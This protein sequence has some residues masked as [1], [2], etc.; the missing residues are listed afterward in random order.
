MSDSKQ[1]SPCDCP[2]AWPTCCPLGWIIRTCSWLYNKLRS[3]FMP[4]DFNEDASYLKAVEWLQKDFRPTAA[5]EGYGQALQYAWRKLDSAASASET[6]D[7]KAMHLMTTFT[8]IS[9]VLGVAINA[10]HVANPYL[11]MP[12]L[13]A[14]ASAS[15]L[16]AIACN[17]AADA[18]IASV[19]DLLDDIG[20]GHAN[21]A[22]L[23]ASIHCAVEGKSC[24]NRWKA[25]RI[26]W[27]T[28]AFC[29]GLVLSFFPF[30]PRLPLV[31]P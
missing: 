4:P 29:L 7:K 18:A 22:W 2:K 8:A 23:A 15:V 27:A 26:R 13:I 16:A 1:E 14:F 17:P 30:V 3:L 24:L 10:W 20:K 6:L 9:G 12:A 5:I 21:D 28:S 19:R 31:G 25:R 11:L